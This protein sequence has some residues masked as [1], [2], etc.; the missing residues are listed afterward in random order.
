ML[1]EVGY[2]PSFING[3]APAEL[4]HTSAPAA[5][6]RFWTGTILQWV[7][8]TCYWRYI[9]LYRVDIAYLHALATGYIPGRNTQAEDN[10]GPFLLTLKNLNRSSIPKRQL[11]HHWS[12]GM[13]KSFHPAV[14]DT[15]DYLSL[16]ESKLNLFSEMGSK[17]R[18]ARGPVSFLSLRLRH[19]LI[20]Y[21]CW[22]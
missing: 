11:L 3:L 15:R 19:V 4:Y 16:L 9:F 1:H 21:P 7:S 20:T 8:Y 18:I 17:R 2:D 12:L 6:S 5:T 13:D 10:S 14:Y 22:N